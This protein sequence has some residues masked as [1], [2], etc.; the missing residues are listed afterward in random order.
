MHSPALAAAL[1]D[2]DTVFNGFASPDETGCGYCHA[3]VET[4]YLRTPYVHVPVDVV[5]YY[6]FEVGD[7]FT[8]HAA[9]M[10]RLLPQ[11]ARAMADGTLGSI[12]YLPHGWSRLDW[13]A[14]PAEQGAAIEAFLI[15]WWQ[16]ALVTP[17][18]PYDINDI[19]ETCATIARTVT[20]FLDGWIPG[21]VADAHLVHCADGWLYDLASGD[22]S[23][24]WWPYDSEDTA[25]VAEL[26]NWL[27]GPGAIRLRAVS[28]SDLAI[29]A[30]L[31]ALPE[32]ECWAHPYWYGP[33]ATS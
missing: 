3:P 32:E 2:I 16:A 8:D 9:S 31:L 23:F 1:A 12:G 10:R 11:A 24:T 4:A 27:G 26:R 13:R 7:H 5:R 21:P 33:S 28:Q 15:A 19:F 22:H 17:D 14:W 29:R 30:E 25:A 20:P 6:L 18:P